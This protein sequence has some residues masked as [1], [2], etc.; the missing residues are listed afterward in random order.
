MAVKMSPFEE[1]VWKYLVEH[2]TPVSASK[3]SKYFI[4]S[5]SKASTA[6]RWLAQQGL[7]DIIQMGNTK[8]YKLKD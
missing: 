2:K 1:S 4:V 7:A 3:L 6:L 8:Y 5:Q